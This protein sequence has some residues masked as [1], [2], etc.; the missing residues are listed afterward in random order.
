ML[1]VRT[2]VAST[3]P[4]WVITNCG[5]KICSP[6]IKPMTVAEQDRRLQERERDVAEALA[7]WSIH[8]LVAAS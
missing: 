3:G 8:R 2:S 6:V 5:M 4:P 1:S 7:D